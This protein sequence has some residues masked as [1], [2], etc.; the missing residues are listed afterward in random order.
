MS[1]DNDGRAVLPEEERRHSEICHFEE[2][3]LSGEVEVDVVGSRM[4]YFYLR[5][6]NTAEQFT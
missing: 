3:F 4:E 1:S 2:V 5:E 6:G